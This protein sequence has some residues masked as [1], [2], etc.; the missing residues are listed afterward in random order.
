MAT[1]V[2]MCNSDEKS[3]V[4]IIDFL[5]FCELSGRTLFILLSSHI[6]RSRAIYL[7][8]T[9]L[10]RQGDKIAADCFLYYNHFSLLWN[11]YFF[12]SR[13]QHFVAVIE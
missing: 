2:R 6:S 5:R 13:F 10:T 12:T 3:G 11:E 4:S 7:A 9:E 8:C 1:L